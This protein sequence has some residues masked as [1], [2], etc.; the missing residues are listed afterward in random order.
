MTRSRPRTLGVALLVSSL[1]LT[2]AGC[3][4]GSDTAQT[5][6][7]SSSAPTGTPTTA[8]S[9]TPSASASAVPDAPAGPDGASG[10]GGDLGE[11]AGDAASRCTVS[12]LSGS[13]G[14][15][16]GLDGGGGAA[17]SYGVAI[18]LDNVGDRA[19]VLQGW[20]GV[21][22]VGGGDGTQIGN[23]A[24]LDRSSPHEA[25]TLQPGDDVQA[26]LRIVQAGNYPAADCEPTTID[27]FRIY[28]PGSRQSLFVGASGSIFEA[29]ASTGVQQLSVGALQTY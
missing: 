21:S 9:V 8:P 5:P 18:F 23:A 14:D 10:G 28:P 1:A 19:C 13:V 6:A 16:G 12:E 15:G 26:I 11:G 17:G 27:G 25:V 3:T 20:P 29:C 7:P 2:V 24:T 22:F 4:A